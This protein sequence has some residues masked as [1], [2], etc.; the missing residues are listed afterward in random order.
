M[1]GEPPPVPTIPP[2]IDPAGFSTEDLPNTGYRVFLPLVIMIVLSGLTVAGRLATRISAKQLG[3]DDY[4][5]TLALVRSKRHPWADLSAAALTHSQLSCLIQTTF[6]A[7]SVQTGYG[8]DYLLLTQPQ[9]MDFNKWWFFGNIFYPITL[10]LFKTSVILLSKR[11]FVQKAFQR[12]CWATLIVNGCWALG[13]ILST[14]FQCV[15]IPMMWGAVTEGSCWG[16][17]A[18]WISIVTWDVSSDVWI[19]GMTVPMIWKLQL[20][21]KE[22]MML[23]GVFLLGTLQVA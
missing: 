2:Y 5:I 1:A 9:R 13:N 20:R 21:F 3:A 12:I 18:L 16:Q 11:I 6:W 8:A 10:A 7:K 14:I 17:N 4:T 19:M 23:M 22:R 15:P